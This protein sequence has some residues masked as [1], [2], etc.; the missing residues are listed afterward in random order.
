[1]AGGRPYTVPEIV[2]V[3]WL[4]VTTV[5]DW[6]DDIIGPAVIMDSETL[7]EDFLG[8]KRNYL[9]SV[10]DEAMVMACVK[11][12]ILVELSI[13]RS[14]WDS[15]VGSTVALLIVCAGELRIKVP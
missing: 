2:A 3:A 9:R 10:P 11:L 4:V 12:Y 8:E 6:S 7:S 1:M 13:N 14:S 5:C 15:V